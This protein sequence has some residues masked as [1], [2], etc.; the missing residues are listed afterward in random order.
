MT[1]NPAAFA[2]LVVA[3]CILLA[4]AGCTSMMGFGYGHADHL[5]AWKA[6]QYFDLDHRQKDEFRVRFAR[7]HS[8][9]RYEQLPDYAAFMASGRQRIER[10]LTGADIQWFVDG[11]RE[12]YRRIV[13]RAA[14]D[15]ADMLATLTQPQIDTLEKQWQKDNR[16]FAREHKLDGSADERRRAR[17]R[18]MLSQI[19]EWTGS[20]GSEQEARITALVNELPDTERA[21]YDDRL[22]RQREFF[23]LIEGRGGDRREFA[24]RLGHWLSN[25]ETGRDPEYERATDAAWQ[26]RVQIFLAVERM[27]TPEQR[28]TLIRR[29]QNH[30]DEFRQLARQGAPE[31]SRTAASEGRHIN[32]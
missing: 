30:A 4:V 2:R 21:R 20:L 27:L 9:H 18:R 19:S 16:R 13:R 3:G 26:K 32:R 25:W 22:R 7:L 10:G 1:S 24:A 12:R 31:S 8:W 15:A 6:D 29:M 28:E 11:V 17:A 14:P 23:K 5:A